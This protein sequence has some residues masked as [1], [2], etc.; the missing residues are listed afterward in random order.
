ML[1]PT[2]AEYLISAGLQ[3][4][5]EP[6]GGTTDS[7]RPHSV[8]LGGGAVV[9]GY[10]TRCALWNDGTEGYNLYVTY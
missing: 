7:H 9:P 6:S 5:E 2:Y 10:G 3:T 1:T 8:L 4:A